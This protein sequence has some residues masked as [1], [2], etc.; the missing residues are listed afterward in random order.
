[1]LPI[2]LASTSI[3]RKE[4][5]SRIGLDFQA[6]KPLFDEESAKLNPLAPSQ[7]A[8]FLACEKARSLAHSQNCVIGGDQLVHF[9]GEIL[10]KS[11]DRQRAIQQLKKMQ[12]QN[13]E[14][15]TSVCIVYAGDLEFFTNITRLFMRSL[16]NSEIENYV[17]FE[18]PFDCAGSY[19]IESRGITLFEKIECT[20]FTAIQGLP[21]IELT[22]RLR[23][24]GYHL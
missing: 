8:E 14:L 17:D 6:Q 18:K 3:Y 2:I 13:H 16:T 22:T 19:K 20:D 10:G 7:M 11:G 4:L 21:L 23:K 5:F 9:K 1:M 24:R 12:G 15:I